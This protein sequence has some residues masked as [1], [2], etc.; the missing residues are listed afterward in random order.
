MR[1]LTGPEA[2]RSAR[3]SPSLPSSPTEARRLRPA[4]ARR[5]DQDGARHRP[6]QARGLQRPELHL[7]QAAR[8]RARR[9]DNVTVYT[10]LVPF[11]G[12]ARPSR[13]GAPPTASGLAAMDAAG[14]DA[15][16]LQPA[17]PAS[18][19]SR[20]TSN[21]RASLGVQGTPTLIW[22]DGSAHR[23]LRRPLGARSARRS[24][25]GLQACRTG[26]AGHEAAATRAAARPCACPG[27][28]H[29][30]VRASAA[31][32]LRLQGARG[33]GLRLGVRHLCQRGA[34]QP[35]EPAD[36][37]AASEQP[38]QC[39]GP[40]A[41]PAAP[42]VSPLRFSAQAHLQRRT[43]PWRCARRPGSCA[44]GSSP[45][46]TPT[47]TSTTRATSTCRSTGPL[48]D[49]PRPAAHPRSLRTASG[50]ARRRRAAP[51]RPRPRASPA[52]MRPHRPSVQSLPFARPPAGSGNP[53]A[54]RPP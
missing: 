36:V 21:W 11:Q 31:F 24:R 33:R 48:A 44:C 16:L 39:A 13:S 10:F 47:A 29:Q 26:E 49:R 34:Q 22:A 20:A 43:P 9:L 25:Q 41:S 8:A 54:V 30:H 1:D 51:T 4:A 45:G 19:R 5:R 42:A 37:G 32:Q 18:T 46:R 15:S 14:G 2:R 23:R 38:A 28:L 7:L 12:E 52:G 27:R 17:R 35:A 6:A 50:A 53:S 40:G 3:P